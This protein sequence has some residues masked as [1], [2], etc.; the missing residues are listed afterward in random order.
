[1]RLRGSE[2]GER[3]L[4]KGTLDEPVIGTGRLP[5]TR[6]VGRIAVNTVLFPLDVLV[7]K[8]LPAD[9]S[10]VCPCSESY[11]GRKE[12]D[13]ESFPAKPHGALRKPGT[14]NKSKRRGLLDRR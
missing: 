11:T 5:L 10:D 12:N 14:D 9:G 13:G 3:G 2:R 8:R 6:T 1:M 4:I 7:G